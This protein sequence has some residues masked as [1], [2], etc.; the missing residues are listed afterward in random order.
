M[1]KLKVNNDISWEEGLGYWLPPVPIEERKRLEELI[2]QGMMKRFGLSEEKCFKQD[3][4]TYEIC[5]HCGYEI[6]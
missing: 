5:P 3:N 4:R 1:A 6:Q 2:L